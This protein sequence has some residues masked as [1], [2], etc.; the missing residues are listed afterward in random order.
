M[1]GDALNRMAVGLMVCWVLVMPAALRAQE[2]SPEPGSSAATHQA[3]RALENDM[4]QALNMRDVDR[5]LSL[6]TDDV[7][8]TMMNSDVRVGRDSL[9]A[10]YEKMLSGPERVVDTLTAKFEADGLPRL[11]GTTGL[12]QGSSVDHY[13]LADGTDLVVHG[14]WSCTLVKQG[15]QWLVAAFHYST[16]AFDNPMLDRVERVSLS[17]GAGVSAVMLAVGF[18]LGRVTAGRPKGQA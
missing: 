18:V 15:E 4:E 2:V 12:A 7:V 17:I 11:Y 8:F 16:N 1:S 6:V 13:V 10:Y 3:L 9:R 5:L 14:R